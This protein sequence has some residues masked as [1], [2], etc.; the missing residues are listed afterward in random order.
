MRRRLRR[1]VSSRAFTNARTAT[2]NLDLLPATSA[3]I[4][5]PSSS[6]CIGG[7]WPVHGGHNSGFFLH[8]PV[9][10]FGGFS[11]WRGPSV[12]RF[13]TALAAFTSCFGA[14]E[15]QKSDIALSGSKEQ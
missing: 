10:S 11:F 3:P 4:L 14:A 8:P 12:P 9:V 7:F 1:R 6:Y 5:F 13:S 2:R 15:D